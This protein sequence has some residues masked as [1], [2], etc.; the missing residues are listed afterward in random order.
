VGNNKGFTLLEVIVSVVIITVIAATV[1][2]N[3][4]K[5]K[6][7]FDLTSAYNIMA[8]DFKLVQNLSLN[9]SE[10]Y[11]LGSYQKVYYGIEILN[12]SSYRNIITN[13]DYNFLRQY[14][15][16]IILSKNNSI[17]LEGREEFTDLKYIIFK[18]NGKPEFMDSTKN[19]IEYKGGK[20]FFIVS[21]KAKLEKA[22]EFNNMT[23]KIIYDRE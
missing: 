17:N 8:G 2:P 14:D 22:I 6:N 16:D 15:E 5:F 7:E 20:K 9:K 4:L 12:S 21:S 13:A 19:I 1:S 3:F 10:M 11:I 18:S 23:G